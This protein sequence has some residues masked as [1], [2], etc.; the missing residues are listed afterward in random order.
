V[1]ALRSGL[2]QLLAGSAL[3]LAC[4]GCCRCVLDLPVAIDEPPEPAP[5]GPEVDLG[6]AVYPAGGATYKPSMFS[7][8]ARLLEP[9]A[10]RA[11]YAISPSERDAIND[12]HRDFARSVAFQDEGKGRFRWV[13]PRGCLGDMH[14][15][16][17]ELAKD[18]RRSLEPLVQRFKK[19]GDDAH[20]DALQLSGLV[21]AFVQ[22]IK[23]EIPETE[24]F[25]I[26]PPTLVLEQKKGDCDSK[27]LLAHIVLHALGVETMLVSSE[28]HR[29]TMLGIALPANGTTFTYAGRKYAFT[30]MT[31]KGSPIGHIN[32]PLLSPSDWKAV[33]VKVPDLAGSPA[34]GGGGAP[35]PKA[36]QRKKPGAP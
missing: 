9:N 6:V 14:C 35:V 8:I 19:R 33:P 18:N 3:V 28:A 25:G 34:P 16:F 22:S 17:D 7:W 30:E 23:Y 13:P 2:A 10:Y 27:A 1:S 24:P 31:A 36:P 20:L 32:P 26:L 29:H 11:G 5:T 4:S 15:V 21:V 12:A